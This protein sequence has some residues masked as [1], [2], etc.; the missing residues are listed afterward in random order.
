MPTRKKAPTNRTKKTTKKA[1][2]S[3]KTAKRLTRARPSARTPSRVQSDASAEPREEDFALEATP[4]E[5]EAAAAALANVPEWLRKSRFSADGTRVFKG[6]YL[7]IELC[8][9]CRKTAL[10]RCLDTGS[11][12]TWNDVLTEMLTKLSKEV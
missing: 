12:T 5:Q 11:A 8:E 6:I 9:Y 10:R 3:K 4:T 7:P 1:A 2:T